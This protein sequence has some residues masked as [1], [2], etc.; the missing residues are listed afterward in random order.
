MYHA[1]TLKNAKRICKSKEGKRK[2]EAE[3]GVDRESR[4]SR[5]GRESKGRA[6]R[7]ERAGREESRE[8]R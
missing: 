6:R 3:L 4:E 7:E 1:T 8:R 5:E 2:G